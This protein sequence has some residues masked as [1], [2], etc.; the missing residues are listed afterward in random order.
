MLIQDTERASR[1]ALIHLLGISEAHFHKLKAAGVF[2]SLDRGVYD[3]K[4]AIA[5]WAK[6]HGDGRSGSDMAE[7]KRRLVIAQRQQI[8][9]NMRERERE[10]VPLAEAQSTFNA[11]MV[12]VGSQ[13]DGLPGRVAGEVAGL[14]D[15]AAVRALLFD[16]C[17]RIRHAAADKLASWAAGHNG[18][19]PTGSTPTTDG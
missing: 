4:A 1:K 8:E 13:L 18:R 17:R 16:E 19:K 10:L 7:E 9:L 2:Q 5:A 14:A 3:L 6:Y 11:T 12:L 15:P